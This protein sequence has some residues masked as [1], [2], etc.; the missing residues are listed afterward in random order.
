MHTICLKW[1]YNKHIAYSSIQNQHYI[2]L[3]GP[4]LHLGITGND[5]D[6]ALYDSP[7]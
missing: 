5:D 7:F 6:I 4:M 3:N 2:A 1:K